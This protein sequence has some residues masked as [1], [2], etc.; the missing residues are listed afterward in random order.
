[1]AWVSE[2]TN[3]DRIRAALG[4]AVFHA[5]L[6]YA[7]V[8]G[9]GVE[10]AT[11]FEDDLKVFQ[12]REAPPP[13]PPEAPVPA[14]ARVEA[15]EGE[16]APP[17]LKARSTPIVAPPPMIR[18]N[19]PPL[20][21][22]A[23]LPTPAVGTEKSTGASDIPGPGIGAGGEGAGTGSGGQGSGAGGG[24]ASR[25]RRVSGWI[26]GASDYPPAARRA[27]I[28]GSVAVRFTVESD[29]TVS[30]CRVTRSTANAE[31]DETTCRLIERRFRYD[32]ARDAAGRPVPETVTRTF[33]WLL[34][35]RRRF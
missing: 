23:P 25:A 11:S 34:P 21:V 27:G 3:P 29:G 4:V 35:F 8:T 22:T 30:G 10:I 26:S 14:K 20:I 9:L 2:D 33:D 12:V 19:P 5:L 13:P 18:L 32:P 17:S 24:I 16:A 7:F 31:L 6:G 15:P 28:E 1:M